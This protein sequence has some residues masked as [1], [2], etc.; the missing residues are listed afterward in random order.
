[1]V[2]ISVGHTTASLLRYLFERYISWIKLHHQDFLAGFSGVTL[3]TDTFSISDSRWLR[4][5]SS[6]ETRSSAST[7][8]FSCESFARA[9]C[10]PC[11]QDQLFIL[12]REPP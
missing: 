10:N 1:M 11:E 5:A 9:S 8:C 3:S 6:L 12:W 7:T 4:R 2:I